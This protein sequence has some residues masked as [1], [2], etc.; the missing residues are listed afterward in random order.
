MLLVF[1]TWP[2]MFGSGAED[3]YAE[4]YCGVPTDGCANE[5][6]VS[7]PR[8]DGTKECMRVDRGG[9]LI[10]RTWGVALDHPRKDS[11]RLSRLHYWTPCGQD[12]LVRLVLAL[13]GSAE[14]D[15]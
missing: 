10:F 1:T 12:A 3:C 11:R 13:L 14:I 2:V 5:T 4:S 8:P 6:G 15:E 9:A 7:D